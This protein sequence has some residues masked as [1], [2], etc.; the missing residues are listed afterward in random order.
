MKHFVIHEEP[1]HRIG[2]LA[3]GERGN[4]S[5]IFLLTMGF[6]PNKYTGTISEDKDEPA[7]IERAAE[8]EDTI[9]LWNIIRRTTQQTHKE[10]T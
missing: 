8:R 2:P 3:T 1:Q 10:L 9:K 7:Q 5:L 4:S 6:I